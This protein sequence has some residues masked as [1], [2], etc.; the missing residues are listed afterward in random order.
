VHLVV[1]ST[2]LNIGRNVKRLKI[3]MFNKLQEEILKLFHIKKSD[4]D[5]A[6]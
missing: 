5:K 2:K 1:E 4:F 6:L 3:S